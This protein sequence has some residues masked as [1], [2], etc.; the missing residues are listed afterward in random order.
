M[1][2]QIDWISGAVT[3]MSLVSAAG[4]DHAALIGNDAIDDVRLT[5]ENRVQPGLR[6]LDELP[7]HLRI[8]AGPR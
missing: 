3:E 6:I 4:L 7:G 1:R 8:L 5:G 2:N